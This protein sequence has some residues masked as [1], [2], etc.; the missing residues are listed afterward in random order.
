[1]F[2]RPRQRLGMRKFIRGECSLS[3]DLLLLVHFSCIIH[4]W[5]EGR[6]MFFKDIGINFTIKSEG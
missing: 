3:I 2:T 4:P 5:G 6:A 1:M